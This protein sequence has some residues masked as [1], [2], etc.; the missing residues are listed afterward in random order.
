MAFQYVVQL[1]PA[2][3]GNDLLAQ[4]PRP[5]QILHITGNESTHFQKGKK[6]RVTAGKKGMT[7]YDE[8]KFRPVRR[9]MIE[10]IEG[11]LH[12]FFASAPATSK[13]ES[14]DDGSSPSSAPCAIISR[15]L[16]NTAGFFSA[17]RAYMT[18]DAP[19]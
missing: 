2:R 9:H 6:R 3:A 13:A 1:F 7:A 19:V 12:A 11:L 15:C 4:S 14:G 8:G 10:S 5:I 17:P 18:V 16:A